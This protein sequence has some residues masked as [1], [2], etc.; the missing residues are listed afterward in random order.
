MSNKTNGK[1]SINLNIDAMIDPNEVDE[2]WYPK[3]GYRLPSL[4]ASNEAQEVVYPVGIK[5]ILKKDSQGIENLINWLPT[6][7]AFIPHEA[8]RDVINSIKGKKLENTEV[9]I[10]EITERESHYGNSKFWTVDTNVQLAVKGSHEKDD[11]VGFGFCFRNGY[12]TG[13]ALGMDFYTM[14]ISCTNG[15]IARDHD[16]GSKTILH[17]GNDSQKLLQ[18]FEESMY[19]A[20]NRGQDLIDFYSALTRLKINQ[21]MATHIYKHLHMPDKYFPEYFQIKPEEERKKRKDAV[22]ILTTDGKSNT[23]W[24][25]F[26]DIT[27]PVWHSMDP[28][29]VNKRDSTTGKVIRDKEG[30]A[31]KTT[32]PGTNFYSVTRRTQGLHSVMRQII[33]DK[34]RFVN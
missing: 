2:T 27:K 24:E 31:E 5:F 8:V 16:L 19:S 29:Q 23:L 20:L 9:K 15:A 17:V 6:T 10:G 1:T 26:N 34:A 22:A 21:K 7:Q 28:V 13:I 25:V 14:R 32:K 12:N 3:Y 11:V 30:K 18:V 33:S 4:L